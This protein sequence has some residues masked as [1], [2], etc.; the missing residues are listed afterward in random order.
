MLKTVGIRLL[1]LL[2]PLLLEE[3]REG[4]GSGEEEKSSGGRIPFRPLRRGVEMVE[5]GREGGKEE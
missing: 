4:G 3:G 1:L 2:L 5:G